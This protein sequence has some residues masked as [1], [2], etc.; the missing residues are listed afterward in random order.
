[1]AADDVNAL[2]NESGCGSLPSSIAELCKKLESHDSRLQAMEFSLQQVQDGTRIWSNI[3]QEGLADL[4]IQTQAISHQFLTVQKR[5]LEMAM[6]NDTAVSKRLF[7]LE[8]Q[9]QGVQTMFQDDPDA[10]ARLLKT[11]RQL[12]ELQLIIKEIQ[13]RGVHD[14]KHSHEKVVE[15]LRVLDATCLRLEQN[16]NVQLKEKSPKYLSLLHLDEKQHLKVRKPPQ[17][18]LQAEQ[19]KKHDS[20]QFWL[21][22]K[23]WRT[24]S[25]S[26]RRFPD[27]C[28][29]CA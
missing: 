2:G 19:T 26:T 27:A 1:M 15:H 28:Q 23:Q 21:R 9:M 29:A 4:N 12:Q 13:H 17:P 20:A 18:T 22:N 5:N 10:V 3:V 16:Q 25:R 7:V 24:M 14:A 8:K 6:E 11:E